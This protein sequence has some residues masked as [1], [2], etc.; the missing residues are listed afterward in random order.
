VYNSKGINM[1]IRDMQIEDVHSLSVLYYHFW[2]EDSNVEKMQKKFIELQKNDAYIF[3]CAI[4]QGQLV[5]TVMG[6]VC[7]E[8]YGE[9]QPFLVLENMVVDN[10]CRRNGVGKLLY[11]E[12]E[13]RAREKGCTQVILVTETNRADACGF[14]QSLGFHPTANKGFKKKIS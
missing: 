7:E 6:I 4:E 11:T 12:L 3:L 13:N 10:A 1:V 14:Y 5:G 2:G 8:L 9:C